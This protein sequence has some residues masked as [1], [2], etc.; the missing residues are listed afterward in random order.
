M[1]D[2]SVS[3]LLTSAFYLLFTRISSE[4]SDSERKY[5]ADQASTLERKCELLKKQIELQSLNFESQLK[6]KSAKKASE[7]VQKARGEE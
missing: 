2:A 5:L 1:S 7:K 4:I 6:E 3:L